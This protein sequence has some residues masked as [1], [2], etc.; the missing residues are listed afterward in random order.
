VTGTTEPRRYRPSRKGEILDAALEEIAANGYADTTLA[1][2]ASRVDMTITAVYYHFE[3]KLALLVALVSHIGDEM[4]AALPDGPEEAVG[5]GDEFLAIF[6]AFVHWLEGHPLKAR[7]YFDRAAGVAPEVEELRRAWTNRVARS[8]SGRVLAGNADLDVLTAR[9]IGLALPTLLEEYA[10]MRLTE[11]GPW[12]PS[13]TRTL[14]KAV[15]DL[16]AR[17]NSFSLPA[18][19]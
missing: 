11:P 2:V 6:D 18:R 1:A 17:L 3:S 5:V 15:V 19:V 9:I 12:S 7:L 8:A 13:Q 10:G 16:G 14:R 4:L